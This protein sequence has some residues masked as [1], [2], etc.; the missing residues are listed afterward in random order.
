MIIVGN[1]FRGKYGNVISQIKSNQIEIKKV[2][3]EELTVVIVLFVF[4][5]HFVLLD[6]SVQA[7]IIFPFQ[8]MIF[9]LLPLPWKV[10]DVPYLVAYSV[11]QLQQRFLQ[12]RK[13]T[14]L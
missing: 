14:R 1:T 11:Q 4:L 6:S 13:Q 9:V 2:K 5:L 8:W 7:A 3:D 10:L 12:P